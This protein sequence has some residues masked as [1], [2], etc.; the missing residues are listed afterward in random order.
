MGLHVRRIAATS[1]GAALV[2]AACG[3]GGGDDGD[4]ARFC[5][6][7]SDDARYAAVFDGFDVTQPARA[8]DQIATALADLGEIAAA[9]PKELRDELDVL[10]KALRDINRAIDD[11]DPNDPASAKAALAA[12]NAR[13]DEI[14]TAGGALA[15]FRSTKC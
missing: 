1:I 6:L 11:I 12:V 8:H 7:A 10:T 2:V 9:A 14:E 5:T 15:T 4:V 13:T 3:G